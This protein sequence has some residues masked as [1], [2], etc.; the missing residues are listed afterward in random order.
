MRHTVVLIEGVSELVQT[1]AETP[2]V[3]LV[4]AIRNSEHLVIGESDAST[5][6]SVMPLYVQF[7]S[8]R[9]GLLLQPEWSEGEA[10]MKVPFPRAK[11]TE[12]P[13]GRGMYA[14]GGRITKIQVPLVAPAG[15]TGM[16]TAPH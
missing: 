10:I 9:R 11:R 8:A 6:V 3:N 5:W 7:R 13:P 1:P 2:L 15:P 4:K 14:S 16:G 12:Y